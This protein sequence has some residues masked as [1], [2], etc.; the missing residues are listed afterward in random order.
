M[1]I[2]H[3]GDELHDKLQASIDAGDI[4]SVTDDGKNLVVYLARMAVIKTVPDELHGFKVRKVFHG[5]RPV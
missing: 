1:D 4:R 2:K 3:A 5:H